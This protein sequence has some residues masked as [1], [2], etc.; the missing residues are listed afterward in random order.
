MLILWFGDYTSK[1]Q[2]TITLLIVVFA[3]AFISAARDH[4]I[5]P[6]QTMSNL[7]AALREADCAAI[8]DVHTAILET[9]GRITVLTRKE[10]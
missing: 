2:W 4:V 8:M 5:H 9:N 6:L 10:R 7:L 1:V 3:A